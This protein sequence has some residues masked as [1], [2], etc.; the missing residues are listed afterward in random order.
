MDTLIKLHSHSVMLLFNL[1]TLLLNRLYGVRVVGLDLNQASIEWAQKHS[2]GD[3]YATNAVDLSWIPDKTFD[4]FF[5]FASVYYVPL[6]DI[7]RFGKE[8]VRVIKPGGS[9]L[10]GWLSG[11][12]SRPFGNQPKSVWD[13]LKQLSGVNISIYDDQDLWKSPGDLISNTGSY[14]VII[15]LATTPKDNST[16]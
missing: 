3:F 7:C 15:K 13:C 6:D 1:Y 5:S 8:V 12:Y 9:A 16:L 11:Q 14:S 2:I 10:F 4:H